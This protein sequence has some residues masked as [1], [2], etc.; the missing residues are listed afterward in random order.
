MDALQQLKQMMDARFRLPDAAWQDFSAAWQP[1][2]FKRKAV[3]TA[4][5]EVER[6][7]YFVVE[8]IQRAYYLAE[9]GT[10]V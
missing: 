9:D 10:D 5:G 8:G 3:I 1:V 7:L 2:G 4:A 6:Y